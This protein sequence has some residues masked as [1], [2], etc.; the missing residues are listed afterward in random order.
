MARKKIDAR[1]KTMS[2]AA[3]KCRTIGH[4]M[5]FVPVSP[6]R[7]LELKQRGQY[8]ERLVCLRGCSRFREQV[9]DEQTD[10]LVAQTGNYSDKDSYLLQTR[11]QGR[12]SRAAARAAYHQAVSEPELPPAVPMP[13]GWEMPARKARPEPVA[14]VVKQA[15][16]APRQRGSRRKS[17]AAT[18]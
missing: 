11:G 16:R 1:T 8:A 17:T 10:E 18:P 3:K 15:D 9:F 7:R 14:A 12:L 4:A 2:T 6:A 5:E 13:E